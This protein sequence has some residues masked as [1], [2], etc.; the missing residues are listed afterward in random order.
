MKPIMST[1]TPSTGI[2][3]IILGITLHTEYR[4]PEFAEV[5]W[6]FWSIQEAGL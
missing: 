2:H 1:N 4:R 3:A 5:V 6:L